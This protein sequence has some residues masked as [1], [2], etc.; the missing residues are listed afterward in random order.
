MKKWGCLLL[1][2]LLTGCAAQPVYEPVLDVY[3]AAASQPEK[4]V[5]SLPEEASVHTLA[6]ENG[7][8]YHCDGYT[9]T[10]QTLT[11]GDLG[12]TLS[13]LTGY[14]AEKLDLLQIAPGR[15]TCAWVSAGEGGDQIGRLV[16]LDDG[17]WHYAVTVMADARKAGALQETWDTLFQSVTL[18]RTG[19]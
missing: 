7:K 6:S 11:G 8:L 4:L 13:V 14:S 3:E 16:L 12:G 2:V 17:V 1:A 15:Y 5:F 18:E 9:L 19:A 10:V